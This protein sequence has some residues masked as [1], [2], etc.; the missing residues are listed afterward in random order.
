[1][2]LEKLFNLSGL[3][4]LSV[5]SC[6]GEMIL[7]IEEGTWEKWSVDA[8]ASGDSSSPDFFATLLSRNFG[9]RSEED[10]HKWR[11]NLES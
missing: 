7:K 8:M 2:R 4:S 10:A 1:M 3:S 9:L 11:Q 5:E 6:G